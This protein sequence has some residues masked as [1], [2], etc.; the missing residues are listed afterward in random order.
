MSWSASRSAMNKF[1][2]TLARDA[3]R[4]LTSGTREGR[5][6]CRC[7]AHVIAATD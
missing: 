1:Y 7:L 2:R 6:V 4:F 3:G 5:A